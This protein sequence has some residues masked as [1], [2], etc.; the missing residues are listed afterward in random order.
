MKVIIPLLSL[1]VATVWGGVFTRP[2]ENL[3][4]IACDVGQGDGIIIYQG[5]TEIVIDGGPKGKMLPCIS[6]HRPFWDRTID[7]VLVTHPQEDH[8]GGLIEVAESYTV[9]LFVE[10]SQESS[11][12]SYTLLQKVLGDQD[13]P[14][15]EASS[16]KSIKSGLIQFDIIFPQPEDH[17]LTLSSDPNDSS[18][19]GRISYGAVSGL[20]TGDMSPR[21]IDY[22]SF[23][24]RLV[25]TTYLKVPH[26]GSKNGLTQQ[27]L[28]RTNPKL[29][30]I[31]VGAKNRYGHPHPVVL[32]LLK[33]I[34]TY[35]TD[36]A[37]DVEFVTDGKT[38]WLAE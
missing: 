3:H 24:N 5:S 15:M 14:T 38:W 30:V 7:V 34:K 36:E 8:Y 25:G 33:G 10:N 19:V 20:F 16:I 37:G 32:E 11:S 2:D 31:S 21:L 1:L 28:E 6:R 9:N 22:L 13:I 12:Q 35:R 18:I 23:K 17:G 29:A 4:I 27:L 26:H